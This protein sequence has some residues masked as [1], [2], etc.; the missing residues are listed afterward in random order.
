M[1][2]TERYGHIIYQCCEIGFRV[3]LPCNAH[4]FAPI[5]ISQYGNDTKAMK[6]YVS[7]MGL[8]LD[9]QHY[10]IQDALTVRRDSLC[11]QYFDKIKVGTHSI[12]RLLPDKRH[13]Q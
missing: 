9:S 3:C 12:H 6:M 1:D 2:Y 13:C 8:R 11:E 4:Q 7:W 10:P 5:F